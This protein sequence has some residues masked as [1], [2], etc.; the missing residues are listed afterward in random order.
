MR[1]SFS[2]INVLVF[3]LFFALLIAFPL[4]TQAGFGVSPPILEEQN[5]VPGSEFTRT[6]YLVQGNPERDLTVTVT[7]DSKDIKD[8]I[9]FPDGANFIIPRGVQQY[10]FDINVAVPENVDLG[11]YR[12]FVRVNTVPVQAEEAG[13][14][15]IALGGRIDATITVGDNIV[16]EFEITQIDIL[17]IPSGDPLRAR[18]EINNTG[19]VAFSP[20]SASFELF[21]KFGNIRLAFVTAEGDQ[22]PL[23]SSFSKESIELEFPVDLVIAPGEYWGHVKIYNS[24]GNVIQELKTVFQ[25]TEGKPFAGSVNIAALG[26]LKNNKTLAGIGVAIIVLFFFVISRKKK[27]IRRR[28]RK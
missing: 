7:V 5:A 17:D 4:T 27:R 2:H 13:E 24:Q 6:I 23:V 21:D 16:E 14:V 19:N 3:G 28:K 20:D 15:A 26:V 22:F 9:S 1:D 25:V 8:W 11:I 18:V 12:A 10:P